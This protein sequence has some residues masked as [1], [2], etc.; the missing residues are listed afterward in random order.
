MKRSSWGL[1]FLRPFVRSGSWT[2]KIR[3]GVAAGLM[4][5]GGLGFIPS[6]PSLE[7][8]FLLDLD[9]QGQTIYDIGG[10][11]GVFTL[12]FGKSVGPGGRVFTFEPNP[13][14]CKKIR[15]N[16]QLNG[17]TNVQLLQIGLGVAKCQSKL[18]FWPDEPARGTINFCYQQSLQQRKDTTCIEIEIDSLDNRIASEPLPP[19][20]F[21]KI[22]VEA[23]ELEVLEGMRQTLMTHHPRLFIEIHAGVDARSLARR[24]LELGYR[25]HH[26]ESNT[27]INSANAKN[28]YDGHLY[29]DC[30]QDG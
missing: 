22:D 25:L 19:P 7:E 24:L 8:K 13:A 21:V 30:S 3:R 15:E 4:R 12:F 11:E 20:D 26:I 6:P 17:L 16:V 29:C 14:N 5:R 18:V 23:A 1:R 2:Y 10:Y 28:V 9:W 27:P